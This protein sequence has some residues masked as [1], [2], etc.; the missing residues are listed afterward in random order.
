[1]TPDLPHNCVPD[2]GKRGPDARDGRIP[3][4]EGIPHAR[5]VRMAEAAPVP[6]SSAASTAPVGMA[7]CW[8]PRISRLRAVAELLVVAVA[9]LGASV[10]FYSLLTPFRFED[11]RW[12]DMVATLGAGC[13]A[14]LAC[15][16]LLAI[17]GHP[18]AS[19]G[20]RWEVSR[21]ALIMV[22]ILIYPPVLQEATQAQRGI[23]TNLPPMNL[24][25]MAALMT[26]V[27]VWEEVVFRGFLLTRLH[28]VFGCWWLSI[29]AG[30]LLFGLVHGYQGWLAVGLVALMAAIMGILFVW[31]RSLVPTLVLHWVHNVGVLALL[32]VMSN[33]WR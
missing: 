25:I 26:F 20:W 28:A 4:L 29:L 1:M 24:P 6:L 30:S 22:V 7:P 12:P 10:V 27:V 11:T 9:A 8:P 31:R 2:P 23:E 13:A 16:V 21:V 17:D 3:R 14:L 33:T 5:P 19:I 32:R 18:P 15:A